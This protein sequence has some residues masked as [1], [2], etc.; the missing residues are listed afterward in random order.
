M[1]D[2]S[3]QTLIGPRSFK[4]CVETPD[5]EGDPELNY[6]PGT[7]WY[8][9]NLTEV[10]SGY[11][12]FGL[13]G[14]QM[15]VAPVDKCAH[16][17]NSTGIHKDWLG[18]MGHVEAYDMAVAATNQVANELISNKN[19]NSVCMFMTGVPCGPDG[20][21]Y[22]KQYGGYAK[23]TGT[24]RRCYY[25]PQ[26]SCE[27]T[28]F[29]GIGG[30]KEWTVPSGIYHFRP[31]VGP[32]PIRDVYF[33]KKNGRFLKAHGSSSSV[34]EFS[35]GSYVMG[36]NT[37]SEI[38]DGADHV[39]EE[40]SIL[41]ENF[42]DFGTVIVTYEDWVRKERLD[43]KP[44]GSG[45]VV[46]TETLKS[47]EYDKSE[48]RLLFSFDRLTVQVTDFQEMNLVY[49]APYDP[50]GGNGL[51]DPSICNLLRPIEK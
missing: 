16:G 2:V 36:C 42:S 6:H 17:L 44:D 3:N 9:S 7:G 27:T 26:P 37:F 10:T 33:C 49:M 47:R 34:N 51:Y 35:G 8:I 30:S 13:Y 22:F 39:W 19:K 48:S 43:I 38:N 50:N 20:I 25:N 46:S 23:I 1:S 15:A 41:E 12:G 40:N 18:R 29:P 11:A 31:C 14:L 5:P 32:Q 4:A 21:Y 28:D 24:E 45:V